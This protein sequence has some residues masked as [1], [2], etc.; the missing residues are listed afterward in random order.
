MKQAVWGGHEVV[1]EKEYDGGMYRIKVVQGVKGFNVPVE[2]VV[3]DGEWHVW[4]HGKPLTVVEVTKLV[5]EKKDDTSGL[6]IKP[7]DVD[8]PLFDS[9]WQNSEKEQ[10]AS[11]ILKLARFRNGDTWGSFTKKDYVEF[12]SHRVTD[13]EYHILDKFA[14]TGYLNKDSDGVYS[15]TRKIIGVYM[16]YA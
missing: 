11:N 1:A 13:S 15:F 2:A 4:H 3:I 7:S 5:P 14:E 8:K 16:Q 10:I 6:S 12:C 9:V